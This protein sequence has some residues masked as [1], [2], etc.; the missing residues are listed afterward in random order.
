MFT[1]D[2]RP[3]SQNSEPF[4]IAEI[5]AN[6]N[7]S[8]E[9]AKETIRAAKLSGAHAVKMQTYTADTMTIDCDKSDFIING[10]LW[11]GYKLYDLYHEAHTP[12]E[13]HSELFFYAKELGIS[14]FSSPFD[15]S[16]VDLLESLN[17]PAYKIASFELTDL[18][19]IKYVAKT[20]K[21][22]LMSTGMATEDEIREA[23]EQARSGGC[24]SIL[25]FHC[26]SSYPAP[27]QES[28]L[29]K[30]LELKKTFGVEVGLSDH[31]LG[32]TAAIASI[33]LGASAI[34]KHFTLSKVNKGLDSAFSIEPH[35][36]AL[37]IKDTR[38]AWLSLGTGHFG[39][40]NSEL[41]SLVFRRSIYFVKDKN[42]GEKIGPEDIKR[43]RPGYGLPPKYFEQILGK[44]LKKDV[45]RGEPVRLEDFQ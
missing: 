45:Q 44:T 28:N 37:L 26:I 25:L 43:I 22:M 42:A 29:H 24:N 4:V 15:E 38:D 33:A 11:N 31:T 9:L 10:G 32:N 39:P 36:L 34:E 41:S 1:I 35:E 19:L 27:T 14:I 12:Y 2:N 30:I 5:S 20:K 23:L 6:H 3:I 7:G 17:A 21:P 18:P 40:S 16:A 8:L 13:W